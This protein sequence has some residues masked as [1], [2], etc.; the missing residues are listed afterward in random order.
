MSKVLVINKIVYYFYS[1]EGVIIGRDPECVKKH[2][3]DRL[4]KNLNSF[5]LTRQQVI[6]SVNLFFET[7]TGLIRYLQLL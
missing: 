7:K 1:L 4:L 2:F 3:F 5:G 6:S